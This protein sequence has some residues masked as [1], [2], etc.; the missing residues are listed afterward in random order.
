[1]TFLDY[2]VAGEVLTCRICGYESDWRPIIESDECVGFSN[3][4]AP[5]PPKQTNFQPTS[6]E[7]AEQALQAIRFPTDYQTWLRCGF[8]IASE[9]GASTAAR[10]MHRYSA[11]PNDKVEDYERT[12]AKSDGRVG[13]G[14]LFAIAK[15]HGFRFPEQP[16]QV[17]PLRPLPSVAPMPEPDDEPSEPSPLERVS[18]E[19]V[20][21]F[22]ESLIQPSTLVE[23]VYRHFLRNDVPPQFAFA[24]ALSTIAAVIGDRLKIEFAD[25][26]LKPN[27]YFVLLASS[28]GGKSTAISPIQTLLQKLERRIQH[29]GEPN[30]FLYPSS[31]TERGLIDQMREAS[32]TEREAG[33]TKQPQRSGLVVADEMTSLFSEMSAAHSAKLDSL[34]LKLWDG[35]EM[36]FAT[37]KRLDGRYTVPPS[38]LSII[39]ASTQAKFREALPKTAFSDGLLA[40]LN[41][42]HC[43]RRAKPR[44][45]IG[46]LANGLNPFNTESDGLVDAL[47]ALFQFV[48]NAPKIVITPDAVDADKAAARR[49]FQEQ[50]EFSDNEAVDAYFNRIA[51]RMWKYAIILAAC[52]AFRLNESRVTIDS[53]IIQHAERI[54]DFF[55]L[56]FIFFVK[57]N[58]GQ[59]ERGLDAIGRAKVKII[60]LLTEK[61]GGEAKRKDLRDYSNFGKVVFETAL[62]ELLETGQVK[63]EQRPNAN[64][65]LV[66]FV[67]IPKNENK[68]TSLTSLTSLQKKPQTETELKRDSEVKYNAENRS[69]VSENPTETTP[70]S[71]PMSEKETREIPVNASQPEPMPVEELPVEVLPT[72]PEPSRAAEPPSDETLVDAVLSGLPSGAIFTGGQIRA[73]LEKH[74]NGQSDEIGRKLFPS[75][76]VRL[77]TSDKFIHRDNA[78]RPPAFRGLVDANGDGIIPSD[79]EPF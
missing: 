30:V 63:A 35:G 66:E 5:E 54:C 64:N 58:G 24:G 38:A 53:A 42:I 8:A 26:S 39:G 47:L 44:R 17:P 6:E 72:V 32:D 36:S 28:G 43:G 48:S 51:A 25:Q 74:C 9:F 7:L 13:I 12:F 60:S 59:S 3:P 77:G 15:Q 57:R 1:M 46:E 16:K 73:A 18:S 75:H 52:R 41:F 37:S 56:Q 34:I 27:D 2:S 45:S 23:R 29:G 11:Q 20:Y 70:P 14:S 76:L 71:E 78:K 21:K 61:F 62:G 50:N 79:A 4:N 69:E 31:S 67:L 19:D 10:M 55:K 22:D 68:V 49:W 65:R 33:A 40:R